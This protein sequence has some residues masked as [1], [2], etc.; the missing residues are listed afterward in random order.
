MTFIKEDF[1]E[2][3]GND[4]DLVEIKENGYAEWFKIDEKSKNKMIEVES[5]KDGNFAVYDENGQCIILNSVMEEDKSR[6]P[7]NGFIVFVGNKENVFK[8][9]IR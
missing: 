6:L 5:P 1:I 2:P 7:E 4:I 3:I 9:K 8:I